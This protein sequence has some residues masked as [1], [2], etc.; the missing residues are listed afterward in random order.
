MILKQSRDLFGNLI[1]EEIPSYKFNLSKKQL[2]KIE[3][4][5]LK[6]L[7]EANYFYPT[8]GKNVW[9]TDGFTLGQNGTTKRGGYTLFKNGKFFN[10][11]KAENWDKP[12]TN[13]QAELTGMWLAI[14]EAE[15]GDEIITDSMNT[16]A[17][18]R[19]GKPKARPDLLVTARECKEILHHKKLNI[20]WA[21]REENLAGHYNEQMYGA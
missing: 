1:T 17:W 15:P 4:A 19:S 18:I 13:N 16:L 7:G 3:R 21:G 9:H 8:T 2:R 14:M 12:Y 20:Y 5:K 11:S 10:S 6:K